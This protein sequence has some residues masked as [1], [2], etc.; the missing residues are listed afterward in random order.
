MKGIDANG[1][2]ANIDGTAVNRDAGGRCGE[3]A[4]ACITSELAAVERLARNV[5]YLQKNPTGAKEVA[6]ITIRMKPDQVCLQHPLKD[7]QPY[8]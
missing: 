3:A 8:R 1:E 6:S 4:G 5:N 2:G 7:L